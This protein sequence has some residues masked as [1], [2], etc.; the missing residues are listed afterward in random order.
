MCHKMLTSYYG[1]NNL[2]CLSQGNLLQSTTTNTVYGEEGA[3]E[4]GQ[5]FSNSRNSC[6][7]MQDKAMSTLLYLASRYH[8]RP[9][10]KRRSSHTGIRVSNDEFNHFAN[11]PATKKQRT[12]DLSLDNAAVGESLVDAT[13][14]NPAAASCY[15]PSSSSSPCRYI[16]SDHWPFDL[17]ISVDSEQSANGTHHFPVHRSILAES[18]EVF[19]VMLGGAYQESTLNEVHLREMVP[20]VFNTYLHH[21]YGCQ[22]PCRESKGKELTASYME[23]FEA[24]IDGFL[25]NYNK[26]NLYSCSLM[27]EIVRSLDSP[28]HKNQVIHYLS[29]LECANRFYMPSLI[30]RC[31]SV[32]SSLVTGD[33][34]VPMFIFSSMYGSLCLSQKCISVLISLQN[35]ARQCGILKELLETSDGQECFKM[36]ENIFYS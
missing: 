32:L 27:K 24:N 25:G 16:D 35:T 8:T 30:E 20:S 22:W 26:G 13:C 4:D 12:E 31:E 17:V 33:N 15:F 9:P 6:N 28:S 34:L 21:V 3:T 10:R 29:V 1:L 7:S 36:I 14:N 11:P 18:S 23:N 2:L 5:L 19:S